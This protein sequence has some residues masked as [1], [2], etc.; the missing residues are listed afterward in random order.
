[1]GKK[2]KKKK[3]EKRRY[4]PEGYR[5]TLIGFTAQETRY[6]YTGGCGVVR[7]SHKFEEFQDAEGI[8]I[9]PEEEEDEEDPE[10]VSTEE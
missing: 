7:P 9:E 1:M 5:R 10:D 4:L 8:W 6:E 3:N 2:K